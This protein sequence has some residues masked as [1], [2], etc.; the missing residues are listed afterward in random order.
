MKGAIIKNFRGLRAL[1]IHAEDA[2]RQMLVG[3]LGRLGLEVRSIDP[4][5]PAL[6][7][8]L[9]GSDIV[10]ADMV[11]EGLPPRGAADALPCIAL[12]GSEAPSQLARVVA[13]GCASHIM[14]PIRSSGVFTALLLAVNEHDQRRKADREIHSL[15]QRMA[16]RRIVTRAVLDLMLAHGLN[17]DDAYERLRLAAMN[18]RLPIDELAREHLGMARHGAGPPAHPWVPADDRPDTPAPNR[19]MTR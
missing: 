9:A 15:R 10:L 19:R 8:A 13:Q 14:K 1:V 11:T 4:Q 2:N 16:G 18:R 5:D 17:H 7:L 6:A 3:V 12:I